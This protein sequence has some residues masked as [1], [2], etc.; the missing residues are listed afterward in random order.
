MAAFS[1]RTKSSFGYWPCLA[2]C[3][4]VLFPFSIHKQD[5]RGRITRGLSLSAHKSSPAYAAF[6]DLRE[7]YANATLE[8]P[9]SGE[10]L[11]SGQI[12]DTGRVKEIAQQ[13]QVVM[14]GLTIRAPARLENETMVASAARVGYTPKFGQVMTEAFSP[15]GSSVQRFLPLTERRRQVVEELSQEDWRQPT[16]GDLAQE[17]VDRELHNGY[18]MVGPRRDQPATPPSPLDVNSRRNMPSRLIAQ[19]DSRPLPQPEEPVSTL[20]SWSPDTSLFRPMILSGQVEMSGGLAFVGGDYQILVRRLYQGQIYEKGRVWVTEGRFEI[21]VGKALGA[22][23]AEL[24]NTRDGRLIGRGELNLLD[25]PGGT[26]KQ[27]R[28]GDLRIALFP[29]SDG[30]ALRPV[31]GY[32]TAS[33]K[34]GVENPRVEIQS[35]TDLQKPNEEGLVTEPTLT[36]ESSFVARAV[37]KDHWS[38]VTVGQAFVPQDMQLLSKTLVNALVNLSLPGSYD[39]DLAL[40]SSIVWGQAHQ[41][42]HP[43]AGAEVEMAGSYKV[44]YF[45]EMYLPDPNLQATSANGLF[46]FLRVKPGVQ[47]LRLKMNGKTYP[48]QIFPTED[49]HVS[50]VELEVR[51][52]VI[53]QFKIIDAMDLEK[54]VPAQI[55]LVGAD[56]AL[57]VS[58]SDF[59]QYS[60]AANP[61][62]IEADAGPDYELSRTT[63]TGAPQLI[64][65]PVVKRE[66][67]YQL[68]Q[69]LGIAPQFNHG[70][71]LGFVD[72]QDF[73]VEMTGYGTKE[74]MQIVYFDS[75]GQVVTGSRGVAGGGFAVFNAPLG[76][77]TVYIHP[78]NSRESYSQVVVAEP[79]YVHVVSWSAGAR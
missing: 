27:S 61:Y 76:L 47:A 33:R 23:V 43:L 18:V 16:P 4:V 70:T 29:T 39:R 71:V 12:F 34:V 20:A 6:E 53:S 42:G 74:T 24:Y 30:V 49:R 11:A 75:K 72:G 9:G 22:L 36:R 67:L 21:Q 54:T 5:F 57:P 14:K 7:N 13:R 60:V 37:A 78:V 40:K 50:Y 77:Q 64:Y 31:S 59:V 3:A 45:N 79:Q 35:Y 48:A 51:E 1:V 63:V 10:R 41:K 52:K 2:A 28:I 26:G 15:R 17:L 25:I 68:Q 55:R 62:M 44:I 46:A 69:T 65:I 32:S 58:D 66:W 56:E 38:T 73:E 8:I 19:N